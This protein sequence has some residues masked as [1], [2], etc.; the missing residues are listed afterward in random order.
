[1][2]KK[3][4]E[5]YGGHNH[6]F[7]GEVADRYNCQICTKVIREPHLAVC[8]GQHFCESCLNKWKF[9]RQGKESCPHCRAQGEG[10]NHVINKGLRSEINQLKVKCSNRG[11]GCEWTGE[12]GA[13][14][15]HLASEKGCGFVVVQC[16]NKCSSRWSYTTIVRKEL[17][18]YLSSECYLRPYKCEYCGEKGTYRD[19]SGNNAQGQRHL[20][21]AHYD[22]CPAYPLACSNECG[23]SGIKRRD[24]DDHRSQCPQEPV[25][26]PFNEA[27]CTDCTLRRHQLDNH[28][29]SNQ[30]KHLLLMMGAYKQVKDKLTETEAKLTTALQ[31]LSTGTNKDKE[32][33]N[34][35]IAYSPALMK[36]GDNLT[37]TMPKVSEYHRSGKIWYSPPFYYKEGY[38]MCLVVS[39][40]K[41][42]SGK[43]TGLTVG[44]QVLQGENDDKLKW[45][46][47][48][49]ICHGPPPPAAFVTNQV[50][51]RVCGLN[52]LET[53]NGYKFLKLNTVYAKPSLLPDH[54][55][56]AVAVL[57]IWRPRSRSTC[58]TKK[59]SF[60]LLV[61]FWVLKHSRL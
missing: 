27:G 55:R 56:F 16:P 20:L 34:S 54:F 61:Y 30:Q 60:W 14:K 45:P 21:I 37:I 22:K 35:I 23:A 51:I 12:L 44:I 42:E 41:M 15:T 26:C 17:E 59:F 47:S 48:H 3:E 11:K 49:L 28:L 9:T 29:A 36:D 46:I 31:L 52:Q 58:M 57:N 53:R 13:L 24:M 18:K 43:C 8:C 7:I 4:S 39:G 50:Y 38:K 19:I 32:T 33:M 6:E 40:M 25:K 5:S 2:A 10:F 1:M